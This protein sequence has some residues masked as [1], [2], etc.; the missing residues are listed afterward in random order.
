MS[1]FRCSFDAFL[2]SEG[3]LW[4]Y[5]GLVAAIWGGLGLTFAAWGEEVA[6]NDRKTGSIWEAWGSLVP[7]LGAQG[8]T[9]AA[10]YCKK[11]SHECSKD[12]FGG[13]LKIVL[14]LCV[15]DVF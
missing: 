14:F 9:F 13:I 10:P 6:Q 15:F 11:N 8:V 7:P 3:H 1:G 12:E 4:G 2:T 5:S